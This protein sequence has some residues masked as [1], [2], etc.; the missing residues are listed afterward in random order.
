MAHLTAL[1][2]PGRKCRFYP[3]DAR[4]ARHGGNPAEPPGGPEFHTGE[5]F[6]PA[7]LELRDRLADP[8]TGAALLIGLTPL[9]LAPRTRARWGGKMK[10]C[11]VT[12]ALEQLFPFAEAFE[13]EIEIEVAEQITPIW[14]DPGHL[15]PRGRGS[16]GGGGDIAW[17]AKS[18]GCGAAGG[19]R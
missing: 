3:R 5:R 16:V 14:I 11:A 6:R 1:Q 18:R 17:G 8:I 9:K 13:I 15:G 2:L 10:K 7:A 4:G 19:R 12:E